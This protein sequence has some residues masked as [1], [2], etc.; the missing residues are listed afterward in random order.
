MTKENITAVGA[1]AAYRLRFA[2]RGEDGADVCAE[3]G[4]QKL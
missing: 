1:A 4:K 3:S 2:A